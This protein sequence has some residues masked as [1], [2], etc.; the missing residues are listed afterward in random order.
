MSVS[1]GFFPLAKHIFSQKFDY[2]S[3]MDDWFFFFFAMF[4]PSSDKWSMQHW[5][6]TAFCAAQILWPET[7]AGRSKALSICHIYWF[8]FFVA[9]PDLNF[10]PITYRHM[11]TIFIIQL[12]ECD[13]SAW[14]HVF[15]M[16]IWFEC[17]NGAADVSGKC[18]QKGA[19]SSDALP[20]PPPQPPT[21]KSKTWFVLLMIE[22]LMTC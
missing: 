13:S 8:L 7:V 10:M 22:P 16:Q 6:N 3:H 15:A 1:G 4:L 21:P 14:F 9:Q 20:R 11:H 5:L 18:A 12:F 2:T 19:S 17:G